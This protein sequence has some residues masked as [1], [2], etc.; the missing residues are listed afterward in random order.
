MGGSI[1]FLDIDLDAFL[2]NVAHFRSGKRRLSGKEFIPWTESQLAGFLE[3]QCGLSTKHPIPGRFVIEHDAAF[4][5]WREI[6]ETRG[7]ELDVSHIDGHADLGL[8]DPSW[9]HLTETHL[10]AP[11]EDRVNPRRGRAFCN[12]GSYMS[13]AAAARFLSKFTYA[14][15]SRGGNDLPIIH[16]LN[17]DPQSGFLQLKAFPPKSHRTHDYE[18]LTADLAVSVE[19]PIPF[20]RMHIEEF[21]ATAPFDYALVCQSPAFTPKSADALIQVLARYIVFDSGSAPLP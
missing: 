17:N 6:V 15:P 12:A 14:H 20:Q 1:R 5:Y 11:V 9:V 21:Q 10:H 7:A 13:Y 19:P 2:S 4:D 3:K 18:R 16:F 8:G